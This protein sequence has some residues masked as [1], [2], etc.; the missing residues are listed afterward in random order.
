MSEKKCAEYDQ[1]MME[2]YKENQSFL[3]KAIF[4]ISTLSIPFLFDVLNSNNYSLIVSIMLTLSIWCFFGVIICQVFS[5]KFARDGC[6]K[7][8]EQLETAREN[9]EKLFNK[10]RLLDIW[11]E[12][13]FIVAF[14]F[15]TMAMSIK[16]IEKENIMSK[17]KIII[18]RSYVPPRSIVSQNKPI[19]TTKV[20]ENNTPQNKPPSN[21][22]QNEK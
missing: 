13:F 15:I 10:A 2:L 12:M 16:T 22:N 5:L 21:N 9:G 11:R 7:S 17:E 6:D 14:L 3:N 8:M 20:P 18:Q 19:E 4:G 1:L